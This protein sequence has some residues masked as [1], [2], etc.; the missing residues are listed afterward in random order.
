MATNL[1]ALL[2]LVVFV[3]LSS[4]V[5]A[6]CSSYGVDYANGGAYYIDGGSN[7]YFSFI[8]VFQGCTAETI[9]PVLVDPDG[10]QYVCSGI[11]TTPAG[12]QVTSTCGIP[13][14]AMR[15]GGW[16][17]IVQGNQ[18]A[19]QRSVTLTVGVPA[20][21]TVTATPT[22][23]IGVTTT[24]RAR[25]K[26][27]VKTA[28][29]GLTLSSYYGDGTSDADTYPR[30]I[31]RYAGLRRRCTD[32]HRVRW[33][34]WWRKWPNT[35]HHVNSRTDINRGWKDERLHVDD[36]NIGVMSLFQQA[37]SR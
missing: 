10:N 13:F 16:K 26:S 30:T 34:R 20:T 1:R 28:E 36:N 7:Q 9:N 21:T 19:V 27:F 17:I 4:N 35:D 5:L 6:D 2:A 32:S 22:I 25:S 8:T 11:N 33:R 37:S 18:I 31:N 12:Q 14:S 15:S 23:I 29:T 3:C 24:P